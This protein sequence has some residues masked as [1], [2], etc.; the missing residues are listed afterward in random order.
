MR[1]GAVQVAFLIA[2]V[3]LGYR[4]LQREFSPVAAA[5]GSLA[6]LVTFPRLFLEYGQTSF[7]EFYA[8]PLQFG[9]LLLYVRP[10]TPSRALGI[11]A[12]GGA[13]LLLKPTLVGIWIAIAIIELVRE[14]RAGVRTVLLVALGA[15]APLAI[16]VVWAVARGVL[17]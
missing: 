4:A 16:V 10:L 1:V 3:L 15:L 12:L 2:A 9:A 13:A 7:V 5:V 8:L 17:G 6:W 11:G 14:R